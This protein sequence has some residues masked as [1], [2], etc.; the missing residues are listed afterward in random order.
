MNA[1]WSLKTAWDA[2][3]RCWNDFF[4]QPGDVRI[5]AAIRVAFAT[6]VLIHFAVLYPDLDLW[7]TA[8]GVLPREAAHEATGRFSWSLLTFLPDTSR[9]VHI[10]FWLAVASAVGLLINLFPRVNAILVFL[11]IASFQVRN[12]LIND[13]EDTLLRVLAFF[14]I[15]L[16]G[17]DKRWSWPVGWALPTK[18]T[19]V[20]TMPAWPLRLVQFQ[21]AALFLSSGLTKLGGDSWLHGTAL[22]YVS[23]L[24]DYFGRF[25]VPA[26]LFDTPWIVALLTW[27]VLIAELA[28]PLLIWFRETRLPCL[29]VLVVF[30]LANEWTMNLFLFH[31][32]MLCGWL[33]F[34]T[35]DDYRRLR[36]WVPGFRGA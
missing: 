36:Q 28:I 21:M 22:Y 15:F 5:A 18:N 13:G 7:F 30:H 3:A 35:P 12:T 14:L 24:D 34:V 9:S 8:G 17:W 32:F 33:A 19:S 31:W 2:F 29:L 26:F 10:A 23:R 1:P 27:S 20:Q 25:W 11:W 6:L 4:H 16:V